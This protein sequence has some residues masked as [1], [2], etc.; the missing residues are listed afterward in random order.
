MSDPT[1]ADTMFKWLKEE[2][3]LVPQVEWE[4]ID[5]A[6]EVNLTCLS[7]LYAND[8][9][10]IDGDIPGWVDDAAF[11]ASVLFYKYI[12]AASGA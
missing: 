11:E 5:L 3:D 6:S 1:A 7:E 9:L 8:E 2:W 4:L 10:D 12:G